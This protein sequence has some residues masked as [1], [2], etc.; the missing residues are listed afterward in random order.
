MLKLFGH[1]R[2]F[3][4]RGSRKQEEYEKEG[5]YKDGEGREDDNQAMCLVVLSFDLHINNFY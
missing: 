1:S 2:L 5:S 3:V 4:C